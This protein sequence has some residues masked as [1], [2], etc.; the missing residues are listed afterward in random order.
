MRLEDIESAF[1]LLSSIL[2]A[3]KKRAVI[4]KDY[5]PYANNTLRRI[6]KFTQN[7]PL[8]SLFLVICILLGFIPFMVVA[9]FVLTSSLLVVMSAIMV[10][11]GTFAISFASLLV[12]MFP[13]LMFGSG[14][15][16]LVYLAYF[17][18]MSILQV[19]K[20]LENIVKCFGRFRKNRQQSHRIDARLIRKCDF[21]K[22]LTTPFYLHP[23]KNFLE[24]N[25]WT[26]KFY[27]IVIRKTTCRGIARVETI[28]FFQ[29]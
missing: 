17:A 3:L 2:Q 18:V 16:V 11:G 12:G 28:L 26:I 21:Q 22:T 20:R 15:A 8:S 29:S 19:F 24:R 7:H 4:L 13:V 5:Q 10:F 23:T 25:Q 9:A 1:P 27:V 6:K 14:V